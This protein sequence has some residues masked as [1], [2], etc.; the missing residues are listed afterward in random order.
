MRRRISSSFV[1]ARGRL[2]WGA[3]P[4]A[5]RSR[6]SRAAGVAFG[7]RPVYISRRGGSGDIAMTAPSW[8]KISSV[9][10]IA[11]FA[12]STHCTYF[13]NTRLVTTAERHAACLHL[14]CA[15]QEA[16]R[17]SGTAERGGSAAGAK[18]G[19]ASFYGELA[20]RD[21]LR[22]DL[23]YAGAESS[24]RVPSGDVAVTTL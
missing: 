12:A 8:R 5:G 17:R 21:V 7:V 13:L 16:C 24:R 11:P 23:Q 19:R 6:R 1:A 15:M 2:C 3:G 4:V 9:S 10:Q 22:S 18:P 14:K 20:R